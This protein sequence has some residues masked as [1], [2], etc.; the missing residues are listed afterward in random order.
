V[1]ALGAFVF[2]FL[3]GLAGAYIGMNEGHAFIY[4]GLGGAVGGGL[5]AL[6]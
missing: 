5:G 4:A 1:A 3:G 6:L 2:G